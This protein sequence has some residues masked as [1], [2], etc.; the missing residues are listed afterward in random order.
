MTPVEEAGKAENGGVSRDRLKAAAL[1]EC[2]TCQNRQYQDGSSDPGVSFKSPTHLSP[3][4]AAAAVRAHEREHV[5]N[6]QASA[7]AEGR[8]IVSQSVQ[9]HTDVCPE[10]G[11]IYVSGG[12]TTT[13]TAGRSPRQPRQGNRLDVRL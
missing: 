12:K 11:R 4:T 9:I 1:R 6:E 10:C 7:R 13:V 8:K 5:E 3:E 2:S